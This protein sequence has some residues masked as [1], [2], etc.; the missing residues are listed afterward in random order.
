[1]KR[2]LII[3]NGV[4]G[5][6]AAENIRSN[7]AEGEITVVTNEDIP[8]YYRIRLPGYLGGKVDEAGLIARK[9]EWY[10]EKRINL[11]LGTRVTE[12][13]PDA[14]L[15]RTEA[16]RELS[17]DMLLLASGSRPFIPDIKG[18]AKAGVYVIYI[19]GH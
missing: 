3:G 10:E 12:V 6:T 9:K 13:V 14:K 4:A 8:F 18:T 19:T 5:T 2:Y 7:D 1:M 17:Y 16:G 15:V 11:L